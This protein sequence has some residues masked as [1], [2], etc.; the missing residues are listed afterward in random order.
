[1]EEDSH[2]AG[3]V[4]LAT[5]PWPNITFVSIYTAGAPAVINF[6]ETKN[7]YLGLKKQAGVKKGE[8]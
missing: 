5:L 2:S 7:F 3:A 8:G 1:M 6:K 4:E